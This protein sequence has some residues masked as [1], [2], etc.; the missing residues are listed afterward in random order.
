VI[1]L[2]NRDQF[3]CFKFRKDLQR[4]PALICQHPL[5]SVAAIPCK[6][7][8]VQL[9]GFTAKS[10]AQFAITINSNVYLHIRVAKSEHA[11]EGILCVT[12]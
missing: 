8:S 9:C 4:K 5:N 1:T 7:A 3:H 6:K 11:N 12:S 2:A 10:I